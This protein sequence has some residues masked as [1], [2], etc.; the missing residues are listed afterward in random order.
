MFRTR[1]KDSG[2]PDIPISIF[3]DNSRVNVAG[4]TPHIFGGG[5]SDSALYFLKNDFIEH[6]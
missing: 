5:D 6:F 2:K 4:T 3:N 1:S